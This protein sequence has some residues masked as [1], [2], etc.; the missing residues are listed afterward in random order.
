MFV[1]LLTYWPNI[2]A[3]LVILFQV[4]LLITVSRLT[5]I[6]VAPLILIRV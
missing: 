4:N 1:Q 3:D 5:C 6:R 2:S